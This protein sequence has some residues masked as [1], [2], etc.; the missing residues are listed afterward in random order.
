MLSLLAFCVCLIAKTKGRSRNKRLLHGTSYLQGIQ[1]HLYRLQKLQLEY[2]YIDH[3]LRLCSYILR[4][5]YSEG[6]AIIFLCTN[7]RFV[8]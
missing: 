8:K 5:V 7:S 2:M 1:D 4:V 6:Y 3:N